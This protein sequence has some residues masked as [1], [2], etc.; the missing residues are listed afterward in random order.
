MILAI[1]GMVVVVIAAVVVIAVTRPSK[2]SA[3]PPTTT[4]SVTSTTSAGSTSTGSSALL[5]AIPPAFQGDCSPSARNNYLDNN[6]TNQVS[7]HGSS[8]P[9]A[10]YVVYG[11]YNLSSD[12]ESYYNGTLLHANGMQTND[13]GKCSALE[14]TG[15]S[16]HGTYCEEP[17]KNAGSTTDTGHTFTFVG[18]S[19]SLGSGADIARLC[20]NGS[21]QG[22]TVLGW[23]DDPTKLTAVAIT[24]TAQLAAAR[25]SEMTYFDGQYDL[26]G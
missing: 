16:T 8:V 17:I 21:N 23:T 20:Q 7:C 9:H 24:C 14:L 13:G 6:A 4:T 11:Q 22:F 10:D 12:S 1:V 19:F 18:T 3:S 15:K 5:T 2:K 26:V 25:A